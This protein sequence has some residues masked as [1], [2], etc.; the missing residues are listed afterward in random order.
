MQVTIKN[1]L[2]HV[3]ETLNK[4]SVYFTFEK[5]NN[6]SLYSK[7]QS[8]LLLITIHTKSPYFNEFLAKKQFQCFE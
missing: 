3:A 6:Y 8:A 7:S 1:M 4:K 2:Q 5:I